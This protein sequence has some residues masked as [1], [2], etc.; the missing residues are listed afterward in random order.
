MLFSADQWQMIKTGAGKEI[1]EN[2]QIDNAIRTFKAGSVLQYGYLIYNAKSKKGE[3]PESG[4][5]NTADQ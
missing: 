3:Q 4:I 1:G 5:A 2:E